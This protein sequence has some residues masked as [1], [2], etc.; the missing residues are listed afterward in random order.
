MRKPAHPGQILLDGFIE[1]NNI[2]IKELAESSW[3]FS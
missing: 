3:V 1:P 2:K